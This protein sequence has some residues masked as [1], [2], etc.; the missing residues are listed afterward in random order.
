MLKRSLVAILSIGT[1][2]MASANDVVGVTDVES[3][4][5][6]ATIVPEVNDTIVVD[7]LGRIVRTA[8]GFNAIDYAMQ[9][10]HY[11]KGDTFEKGKFLNNWFIEGGAGAQIFAQHNS[12]RKLTPVTLGHLHFGKQLNWLST[13]R[14]GGELGLGFIKAKKDA[15]LY[16]EADVDYMFNLSSYLYGYRPERPFQLS[17]FFGVGVSYQRM[18]SNGS[19][20]QHDVAL[21]AHAGLQF[22]LFAGPH[23]SLAVE[24]QIMLYTTHADMD[25]QSDNDFHQY[26]VAYKTNFKYIYYFDNILSR[27]YNAG[28]FKKT[29]KTFER[30]FREDSASVNHR[31]PFFIE[32]QGGIHQLE[33]NNLSVKDTRGP[34]FSAY[35]GWWMSNATGIRLGANA[36]FSKWKMDNIKGKGNMPDYSRK[37][38]QGTLTASFDAML[39]PLGFSR[40][41]NW[42]APAGVNLIAGIEMGR[43]FVNNPILRNYVNTTESRWIYGY[44]LGGQVWVRLSDNLH[45][46]VEPLLIHYA[47]KYPTRPGG[48]GIVEQRA[49]RDAFSLKA[50]LKVFLNNDFAPESQENYSQNT[51]WFAGIG[52]GTNFI[53]QKRYY[54][55]NTH[56]LNGMIYAG[57]QFNHIHAIRANEE[58]MNNAYYDATTPHKIIRKSDG[59]TTSATSRMKRNV[60][61]SMTSVDY[62]FNVLN[63]FRCGRPSS[64]ININLMAGPVLAVYCGEST[65]FDTNLDPE[66]YDHKM[67]VNTSVNGYL[68]LHGGMNFSI[69]V[70]KPISLFYQHNLYV[71]PGSSNI[72]KSNEAKQRHNL[73]NTL[74]L[75]LQYNF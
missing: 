64:N 65:K 50:G 57:Y 74:N 61:L 33:M 63:A 26:E 72:F 5:S 21:N 42:N 31:Q 18:K 62:Q 17:P 10:R 53:Y 2:M 56:N 32:Y 60:T 11:F 67:S 43:V 35:L 40:R 3:Q 4:A 49:R 45:F 6:A 8:E 24:P 22:K 39:N 71:L 70:S 38:F 29:F 51:G 73:L 69:R 27:K 68:G 55:G 41:Y 13:V 20:P 66:L 58:I 44:R 46:E 37:F 15:Y 36:T 28:Q 16:A 54:S 1:F 25:F 48:K 19:L 47:H 23:S 59:K 52:G 7:S 14:F 12:E 34:A 30:Y 9:S 75:G